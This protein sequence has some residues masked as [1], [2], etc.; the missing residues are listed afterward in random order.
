MSC[1]ARS[2]PRLTK[3]KKLRCKNCGAF[4]DP[5]PESPREP[6]KRISNAVLMSALIMTMPPPSRRRS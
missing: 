5:P 6:L 2:R 3:D 1:C 4:S